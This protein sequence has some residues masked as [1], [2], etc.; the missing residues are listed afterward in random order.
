MLPGIAIRPLRRFSDERGFFA[1]LIRSDWIDLINGDRILQ[2]NLSMTYPGVVRAWHRHGRGQVDYFAVVGGALKLCA[3]DDASKELDEIIATA[4]DP[5]IIRV[6]GHYWHGFKAI[7]DE[8]A[9]LVYF[10]NRLY[11]YGDP[12][13]VRRP[14]NDPAILPRSI[15]GDEGDPRVGKPW[16]WFAPP[17]R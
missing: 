9:L 12:D 2:A 15:N 16:D 4:R 5:S 11:D 8:P 10:V 14:W 13:E 6:P 3:Y 17:H 1:E 7:G